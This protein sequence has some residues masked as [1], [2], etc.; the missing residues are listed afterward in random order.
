MSFVCPGSVSPESV[1]PDQEDNGKKQGFGVLGS[2]GPRSVD[3][4]LMVQE[5]S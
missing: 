2:N 1:G 4:E 3:Q 5:M